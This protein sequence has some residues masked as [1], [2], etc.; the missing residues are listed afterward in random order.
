MKWLKRILLGLLFIFIFSIASV[1]GLGYWIFHHPR[2]SW[3]F[4][5]R[6][7]L[8]KDLKVTWEQMNFQGEYLQGLKFRFDW[9]I[10]GLQIEKQNPV[11]GAP[12]Q[13]VR[14]RGLLKN[15][16]SE[17]TFLTLHDLH[18]Q[19]GEEIVFRIIEAP[20]DDESA[21]QSPYELF[22]SG[23]ESLRWALG[24]IEI[25]NLKVDLPKLTYQ[26]FES[27]AMAIQGQVNKNSDSENDSQD[28]VIELN[29]ELS[30]QDPVFMKASFIGSLRPGKIETPEAFL[31][32]DLEF[33]RLDLA[34]KQNVQV[35]YHEEE[36][37][38]VLRG[39]VS[40]QKYRFQ[41]ELIFEL[42]NAEGNLELI[43]RVAGIPHEQVKVDTISGAFKLPF[44]N[45]KLWSEEATEFNLKVPLGLSFLNTKTR[46]PIENLC[47][48]QLPAKISLQTR[49]QIWLSALLNTESQE[50]LPVVSA[51]FELEKY[52]NKI[53]SIEAG[54]ALRME[55]KD[56]VFNYLPILNYT[57]LVKSFQGVRKFLDSNNYMIPAPF[58]ILEGEVQLT[59][60]G[61]VKLL[62]TSYEYQ[63]QLA[64]KLSSQAQNVNLTIESDLK[65]DKQFR[66]ADLQVNAKIQKF[67]VELP[68]LDPLGGMPRVV[69]NARLIRKPP[70]PPP[71]AAGGGKKAN[72][73]RFTFA[74]NVETENPGAIELLHRFFEPHFPVTLNLLRNAQSENRGFIQAEPFT[75]VY[76]RRRVELEKMRIDL[77]NAEDE[78]MNVDGRFKIRQTNYDIFVHIKGDTRSPSLTLTSDPYLPQ[79]Q[80]ISVL[81][82]DR[83]NDQLVAADAQTA[84]SF[85]S[86]VADRAIGL[87]GL[88]AFATTPIKS[89]SYNPA[90][91]VYTA[92]VALSDD[93]TVGVGSDWEDATNFELRKRV[94]R[95]W[96]LMATWTPATHDSEAQS[97]LVLQWEKR[98]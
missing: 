15:P 44:E 86:A 38:V 24:I 46:P 22:Q 81:L 13:N 93:T 19:A 96:V 21:E 42:S 41:P 65:L 5:Q 70:P 35:M 72:P 67:R 98:F 18:I 27:A 14:V 28:E 83:T 30:Q 29:V 88:W 26:G 76:L 92:T 8:P 89:F 45:G 60:S 84:G 90:T 51:D 43:S 2:E 80:I 61:P 85:Q 71:A 11:V 12:L 55:K 17:A 58:D 73:F 9:E 23:V 36:G 32:G 50:S 52:E 74:I 4:V 54:G 57:V 75:I 1:M 64:A 78:P 91:K 69:P 20:V 94:S 39:P 31:V 87:F 59:G 6:N 7:Y 82:Y 3:D 77:P 34:L 97:K 48:C 33:S 53:F 25:Q 68:P 10:T 62:E 56:Q 47:E 40:Y 63:S 16:F 79:D 49:G 37:R 95:Q 66:S